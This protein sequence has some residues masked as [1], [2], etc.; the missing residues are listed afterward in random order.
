MGLFKS[1][2]PK[3]DALVSAEERTE[4]MLAAAQNELDEVSAGLILVPKND[5]FSTVE[6]LNTALEGVKPLEGPSSEELEDLRAQVASL[7]SELDAA[8]EEL[9]EASAKITELTEPLG[10][11][12]SADNQD[13]AIGRIPGTDADVPEHVKA[14]RKLRAGATPLEIAEHGKKEKK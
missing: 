14:L 13:A 2:F 9:T 8:N 6:E 4:A 3:L 7:Q 10:R 12:P 11:V 1:R 5:D